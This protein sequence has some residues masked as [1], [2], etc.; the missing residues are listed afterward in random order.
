MICFC[1][2]MEKEV[3][4]LLQRYGDKA[5]ELGYA[6]VF[7]CKKGDKQFLI[8]VS[9][10]GKCFAAMSIAALCASKGYDVECIINV[11]VGGSL[12]QEAKAFS[13]LTAASFAQHDM[14][15]TG[16]GDPACLISGINKIEFEADPSL[17]QA[18]EECAGESPVFQ[19]TVCSGD[20]FI[21]DPAAIQRI[22]GL[23]P[24]AI[25]VDMESAAFAQAAYVNGVPFA[26]ARF[27]S[28][29]GS[30]EEYAQNFPQCQALIAKLVEKLVDKI[31]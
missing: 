30:G 3:S 25:C 23:F 16:I 28:D 11:G 19:G 7:E 13:L 27:V 22:L 14:D 24:N 29:N 5:V 4:P 17:N 1:A 8:L 26:C 15:T 31:A 20:Q 12:K 6:K 21:T 10:V 2:A 9:G 18:I